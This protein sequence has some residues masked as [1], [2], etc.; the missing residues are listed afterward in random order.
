MN[1]KLLFLSSLG[2]LVSVLLLS[3]S[4][5]TTAAA[6]G[7]LG[8]DIVTQGE[9]FVFESEDYNLYKY[10][11]YESSGEVQSYKSENTFD[12][13]LNITNVDSG[14]E[15]IYFE[16]KPAFTGTPTA[17]SVDDL[18]TLGYTFSYTNPDDDDYVD[19]CGLNIALYDKVIAGS[20]EA[21]VSE[22]STFMQELED[23][24]EAISSFDY[25]LS[26]NNDTQSIILNINYLQEGYDWQPNSGSVIYKVEHAGTLDYNNFVLNRYEYSKWFTIDSIE[27]ESYLEDN[28]VLIGYSEYNHNIDERKGSENSSI[29]GYEIHAILGISVASILVIIQILKRKRL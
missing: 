27:N 29:P 6:P 13:T 1:K 25:S 28:G 18:D 22:Y 16:T 11:H 19:Y 9:T 5:T 7:D 24:K 4:L 2:G 17:Y 12:Y 3:F 23:A 21:Y 8:I 26:I 15:T 14:M 10:K 20:W